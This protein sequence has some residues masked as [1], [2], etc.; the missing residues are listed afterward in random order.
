M[1]KPQPYQVGTTL[2]GLKNGKPFTW[3]VL[4]LN[5]STYMIEDTGGCK[6]TD[7]DIISP[8]PYW[9]NCGGSTGTIEIETEGSLW[10]LEVGKTVR[11][12][13]TGTNPKG[14][15]ISGVRQCKAV[16]NVFVTTATGDHYTYKVVCQDKSKVLTYYISP[17][18]GDRV[19]FTIRSKKRGTTDTYEMLEI[20]F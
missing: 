8:P 13:F 16:D 15:R 20:S 19:L 11:Y 1:P 9:E 18:F 14:N 10:P 17:A 2:R 7:I 3:K 4:A 5:D 12:R 6:W